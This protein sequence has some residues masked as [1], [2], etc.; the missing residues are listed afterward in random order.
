MLRTSQKTC[1]IK[2]NQQLS[3]KKQ[4]FVKEFSSIRKL[5]VHTKNKTMSK[6]L[7][8]LLV[9]TIATQTIAFSQ[10]KDSLQNNNTLNEVIVTANKIEQK[11]RTTGKVVTIISAAQLEAQAGKTI[12]QVLNE[13]AGLQLPGSLSNMGTVPSIYMRGASSGRTLILLDGSPVGDP[14]MISNEFDLNLV[15]IDQIERI[16]ILKGSQ[17]TMYGSDAIGGVINIITKKKTSKA[18]TGGLSYGSYGTK[19]A[20][21]QLNGGK[22]KL[23]YLIGL[24]N[25]EASG[26]SAAYDPNK[27]STY[28]NDGYKNKSW[29]A[30]AQYEMNKNWNA[31]ISTKKTSYKA[32][33][34]YGA[35]KDD[36]DAGFNNATSI[37]GL[38]VKYK[39]EQKTFQFQY[40]YTTQDRS[41]LNDSVDQQYLIYENNQY[42]GK[43]HFADLFYSNRLA[44]NIQWIIGS[45]FRYGSYNQI[46]ES[47]SG[48]GPYNENFKDT[49][50]FQNALYGSIIINDASNKFLLELGT[51]Y[52]NHSR[53]GANQTF[54]I[55]PSYAITNKWR[56]VASI[57]S[58]FKA[59]SLYQ[60]SYN[61]QLKAETSINTELGIEYATEPLYARA[62][63]FNRKI[64][65]GIDYNYIDYNFFNFIQQNVN[66]LEVEMTHKM[67]ARNQFSVNYTLLNGKETNQ[68]RLTNADTITYNYLLKRPKHVLN[69]QYQASINKQWKAQLSARYISKRYDV[70]GYGTEDVVLDYYTLLNAHLSYQYSKHL[71]LYADAQNLL[72]DHFQEINGYNAMGRTIQVGLI[73]R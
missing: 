69:I 41:Y 25:Q 15:P 26:F 62:V 18:I 9:A 1:L 3:G 54:T 30:K 51:R 60:I 72:N 56:A 71:Q 52:N 45:D 28:D 63:F 70:G 23:N 13:Q 37:S 66:G 73:W 27:T 49:F 21:I 20:T 42:K 47:I 50:Q 67:N 5:I 34:D 8:T 11:Q 44:K 32:D 17:S 61:D 65:N 53:Y 7:F 58:G 35:F 64:N 57:S 24:E 40:Q 14:S 16:E 22:K 59:P 31:K 19:K 68:N 38:T 12:A 46:Y 29:F 2:N 48:W 33:I 43:T 4:G 6:K 55:S 39:K 10:S 36:K